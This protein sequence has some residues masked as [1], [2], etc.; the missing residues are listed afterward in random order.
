MDQ[1]KQGSDVDQQCWGNEILDGGKAWHLA[2]LTKV[3]IHSEIA[4]K[5]CRQGA[6]KA[7]GAEIDFGT[8]IAYVV[9]ANMRGEK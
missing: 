8:F 6:I 9:V 1:S 4:R 7:A 5:G 2:N 3:T